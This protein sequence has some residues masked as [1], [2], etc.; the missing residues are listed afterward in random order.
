ML[1]PSIATIL[2][3]V[4]MAAPA[5]AAEQVRIAYNRL[6]PPFSEEKDGKAFGLVVDLVR[7]A[8]ERAG[9]DVAFIPVPLE[10]MEAALKDGRAVA[11]IPTAISADRRERLDFSA[12]V[13]PTGGALFVRAPQATPDDLQAL[14]GKTLVT[15]RTGPLAAYIQKMAPGVKLVVTEDYET[16]LAQLAKGEADA[17]ALNYQTGAIL[18]Q[19]LYPAQITVPQTMFLELPF[20][21]A[22]MKGQNADFLKRFNEGLAAIRA[23]N[24]WADINKRWVK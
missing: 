22:V 12:P 21:A 24:T 14:A 11:T 20:A 4:A 1:A 13:L 3:C 15:P 23:D 16:S 10:Q 2:L 9:Y 8:A 19:R 6:L 5:R 7:A 18:A 17:A